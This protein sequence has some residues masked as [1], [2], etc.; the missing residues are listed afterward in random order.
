MCDCPPPHITN[1]VGNTLP[2]T[3]NSCSCDSPH[4]CKNKNPDS[5]IQILN[6]PSG[7]L[8]VPGGFFCLRKSINVYVIM[9]IWKKTNQSQSCYMRTICRNWTKFVASTVPVCYV[10]S[11]HTSNPYRLATATTRNPNAKWCRVWTSLNKNAVV[12]IV[13]TNSCFRSKIEIAEYRAH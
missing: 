8:A 7:F 12:V 4:T 10:K 9:C 5:N 13:F 6:T 1:L 2:T 3:N 11:T